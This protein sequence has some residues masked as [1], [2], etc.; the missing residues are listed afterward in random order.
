[1]RNNVNMVKE[2]IKSIKTTVLNQMGLSSCASNLTQIESLFKDGKIL[3][4]VEIRDS[5]EERKERERE[6]DRGSRLPVISSRLR[7]VSEGY[8][9]DHHFSSPSMPRRGSTTARSVVSK[10]V[11]CLFGLFLY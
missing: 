5:R 11:H 4:E 3:F 2:G 8:N 9:P 10:T 7:P 6:R 1:M